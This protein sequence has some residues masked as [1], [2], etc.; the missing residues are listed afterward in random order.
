MLEGGET[1]QG[2]VLQSTLL[3]PLCGRNCVIAFRFTYQ[4]LQS[5]R[6]D[7]PSCTYTA[8][9][10]EILYL[11][12]DLALPFD[13]YWKKTLLP[14]EESWQTS[15]QPFLAFGAK[16]IWC[17]YAKEN[18]EH[19]WSY[20]GGNHFSRDQRSLTQQPTSCLLVSF[21]LIAFTNNPCTA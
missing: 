5:L 2:G 19:L 6:N 18:D 11:P 3:L 13:V 21:L 15:L 10:H 20:P 14:S 16:K 17:A 4:K 12:V 9:N 8:Y 1:A 7:T